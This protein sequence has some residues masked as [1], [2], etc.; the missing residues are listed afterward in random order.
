MPTEPPADF[1]KLALE[2]PSV[3]QPGQAV[4]LGLRAQL[5]LEAS[6]L[7]DVVHEHR[8][9]GGAPDDARPAGDLGPPLV[10]GSVEDQRLA[11]GLQTCPV[12]G[13]EVLE[14]PADLLLT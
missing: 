11:P 6:A 7:G 3:A 8:H 10:A 12:A 14:L 5:S 1:R 13:R 9:S 2:G 4:V